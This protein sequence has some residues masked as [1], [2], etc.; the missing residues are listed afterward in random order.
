M[1]RHQRGKPHG[2]QAKYSSERPPGTRKMQTP[3]RALPKLGGILS[4]RDERGVPY[5]GNVPG[6]WPNPLD[7]G[8]NRGCF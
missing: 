2:G 4:R 3:K 1:P 5:P 6:D 7:D 8:K